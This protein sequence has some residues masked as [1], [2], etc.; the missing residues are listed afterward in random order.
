M[1]FRLR[2]TDWLRLMEKLGN[3]L[4]RIG[5]QVR[6]VQLDHQDQE[7]VKTVKVVPVHA[8]STLVSL[9]LQGDSEVSD[10]EEEID[11]MEIIK[12]RIDEGFSFKEAAD[13]DSNLHHSMREFD[14]PEVNS[15]AGSKSA[16]A[17]AATTSN[18]A[19]RFISKSSGEGS[20]ECKER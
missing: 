2:G 9:A 10:E 7:V 12:E 13:F 5:T 6:V 16:A 3:L 20:S 1:S 17:A 11:E 19:E 14:F 4:E 15:A 8:L 18:S